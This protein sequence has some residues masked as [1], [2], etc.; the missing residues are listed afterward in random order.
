MLAFFCG[1]FL[2]FLAVLARDCHDITGFSSHLLADHQVLLHRL[3]Q[4]VD[5][6]LATLSHEFFVHYLI[7][8]SQR[9]LLELSV[10]MCPLLS[11]PY[12]RRHPAAGLAGTYALPQ[13]I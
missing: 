6:L 10:E 2:D 7:L 11:P 3:V 1:D 13:E 5:N 8:K 9:D 12:R 4:V